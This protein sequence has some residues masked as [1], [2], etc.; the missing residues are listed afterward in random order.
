MK[1]KFTKKMIAVLCASVMA[2]SCVVSS[3]GAVKTGFAAG[4]EEEF[5]V[6]EADGLIRDCI[7]EVN[8]IIGKVK[9]LK[10]SDEDIKDLLAK[11]ADLKS[12]LEN[13]RDLSLGGEAMV[14]KVNDY[15][16]N[17]IAS[18]LRKMSKS[19]S[20][21]RTDSNLI[22]CLDS[23]FDGMDGLQNIVS[24]MQRVMEFSTELS[25]KH[26][27][28]RRAKCSIKKVG[29]VQEKT[30]LQDLYNKAENFYKPIR[31]KIVPNNKWKK[32]KDEF[33]NLA[34][35]AIDEI[36]KA[37]DAYQNQN[38]NLPA[39]PLDA[40]NNNNVNNNNNNFN[41]PAPSMAGE[42][43][44]LNRIKEEE[45]KKE[46]ERIREEAR[47]ALEKQ[48]KEMD[49][50]LKREREAA[51]KQAEER[52]KKKEKLKQEERN[53]EEESKKLNEKAKS[54]RNLKAI[55]DG[56]YT[57]V[58]LPVI[59]RLMEIE[60]RLQE[61]RSDLVD[62]D[63]P[64]MFISVAKKFKNKNEEKELVRK[65]FEINRK[66][67]NLR[68]ELSN[69]AFLRG[70][71]IY[72]DSTLIERDIKAAEKAMNEINEKIKKEIER[73]NKSN[74]GFA[75]INARYFNLGK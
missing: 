55:H 6:D 4:I 34:N 51:K 11:L 26:R 56:W 59:E 17:Y 40:N 53:L 21:N 39:P 7:G 42:K 75:E 65:K 2:T 60:Y 38:V 20:E 1:L 12:S 67:V 30:R 37:C 18:D 9:R 33:F 32:Q 54:F 73:K 31:S 70:E 45:K 15:L 68:N 10:G 62:M 72:V 8:I 66:H 48:L 5:G 27:E 58:E 24:R 14:E 61:V 16:H 25:G 23:Y 64:E 71:G 41:L 49:E 44:L 57:S 63:M 50:K 69:I 52:A 19:F 3:V 29:N 46:K 47:K 35:K 36:K 74:S 22:I 43:E 13:T 28:L